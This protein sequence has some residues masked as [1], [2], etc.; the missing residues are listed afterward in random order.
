MTMVGEG[1]KLLVLDIDYTLFDHRSTAKNPLELMRPS[2]LLNLSSVT[3]YTSLVFVQATYKED[4][5]ITYFGYDY[6]L[7]GKTKPYD[8][9][10]GCMTN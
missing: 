9:V 7:T 8:E 2:A 4:E 1:K 6:W 5:S 3:S 10:V